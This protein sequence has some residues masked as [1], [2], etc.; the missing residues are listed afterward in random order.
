MTENSWKSTAAIANRIRKWPYS[1]ISLLY[2][3]PRAPLAAEV[4]IFHY[5]PR[6]ASTVMI[7]SWI[8]PIFKGILSF[9]WPMISLIS[10]IGR[11]KKPSS[12][13]KNILVHICP[14]PNLVILAQFNYFSNLQHMNLLALSK[15]ENVKAS[16]HGQ[17]NGP[18]LK[19]KEDAATYDFSLDLGQLPEI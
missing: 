8:M 2:G 5:R 7:F 13:F 17:G 10:S 6:G 16:H 18:T 11:C 19:W 1:I 14:N 15:S 3:G 4:F 9:F 12:V